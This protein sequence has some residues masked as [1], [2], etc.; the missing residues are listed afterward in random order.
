M[1]LLDVSLVGESRLVGVG[2]R[3]LYL[4]LGLLSFSLFASQTP[5]GK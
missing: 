1:A 2:S 5:Q 4:A 3:G